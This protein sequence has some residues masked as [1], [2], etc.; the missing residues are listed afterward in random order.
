MPREYMA[1][2]QL[3]FSAWP[4]ADRRAWDGLFREGDL[5]TDAGSGLHWAAATRRTNR[6]HYGCF[7]K[8]LHIHD[9]LDERSDPTERVTPEAVNAYAR[10]MMAELAPKTVES[11]LIGLKVV[12]KAL[13]PA[14]D[15][16]WFD[17][18]TAR[19]K[20]WARPC[21]DP[22]AGLVPIENVYSTCLSEL[23]RLR[24]SALTS[25]RARLA[26]RDT[27]VVAFFTVAPIRIRNMAMIDVGVH[28]VRS[29]QAYELRFTADQTKNRRPLSLQITPE[30]TPIVEHYLERVRPCFPKSGSAALWLRAGGGRLALN[31]I[32]QRVTATTRRLL[33]Q[34]V[35][36]HLFRTIAATAMADHSPETARLA[37]PLLGHADF[38]TTERHYICSRQI[39]ASRK[40]SA[41]LGSIRNGSASR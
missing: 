40:I 30:L 12:A 28:L 33:G 5:L 7:L 10:S 4:A 19:V 21:R 29:D 9:L 41:I 16:R 36:P 8:W 37:A 31:S 1:T 22:D 15:W 20:R 32:Y 34:P 24:A 35:N 23:D 11:S 39:D 6:R 14:K 38:G 13:A 17:G 25:V 18:I 26:Y 2:R 27:L 3:L